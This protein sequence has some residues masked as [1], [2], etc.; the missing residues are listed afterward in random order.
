M[1]FPPFI[2]IR[3]RFILCDMIVV[4]LCSTRNHLKACCFTDYPCIVYISIHEFWWTLKGRHVR[5]YNFANAG[6]HNHLELL[7][8]SAPTVHFRA[9]DECSRNP[10]IIN[11]TQAITFHHPQVL[12]L[13]C[14]LNFCLR[15][16]LRKGNTDFWGILKVHSLCPHNH[17][18]V[19]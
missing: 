8:R 10:Q 16:L 1:S 2:K 6:T 19:N 3:N 11:R 7:H 13:A 18:S 17:C 14:H 9:Q 4:V 12:P 15:N 5:G